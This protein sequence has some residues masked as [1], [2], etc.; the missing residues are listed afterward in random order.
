MAS[1]QHPDKSTCIF[2]TYTYWLTKHLIGLNAKRHHFELRRLSVDPWPWVVYVVVYFV[3]FVMSFAE[4]GGGV[5][6]YDVV[7]CCSVDGVHWEAGD[8]AGLLG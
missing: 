7:T 2:R 5:S 1:D 4:V 8:L 6:H 3:S